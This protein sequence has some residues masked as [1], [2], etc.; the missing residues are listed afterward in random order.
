VSNLGRWDTWY[1][2]LT[3][4]TPQTYGDVCTYELG[5]QWLKDCDPIYDLGCG[6]GGFW[7]TTNAMGMSNMVLGVDG[8]NTPFAG[9]IVDLATF[10]DRP[11]PGVFMRHVIEHDYR[12][13][14][15]L[16]NA[17]A[18]FTD[19]MVLVL[20]TP[21]QQETHEIDWHDD[22]GVPDIGFSAPELCRIFE[23]AGVQCCSFATYRTA[24][25]YGEE[26]VF[27][28]EKPL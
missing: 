6:K 12:W 1:T 28:L 13:R 16:D 9:R 5:A 4:D 2:G 22:I 27:L 26:T 10:V 18:L 3:L 21:M 25:Q 11:A 23:D 20:F 24:T 17:F 19:R 8:S 14:D 15:I 7:S